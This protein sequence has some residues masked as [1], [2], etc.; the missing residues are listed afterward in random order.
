MKISKRETILIVSIIFL[1]SAA[2]YYIYFLTPTIEEIDDLAIAIEQ[3]QLKILSMQTAIDQI[4]N[5]K[6][7]I[8]ELEAE[9][10]KQSENIPRGISQPIQLVSVS[11]IMNSKCDYLI[12]GFNPGA[13]EYENYQKNIVDM[14]FATTYEELLLILEEF[15][16]LSMTNQIA[17]MNITF[18]G[19][20]QSYYTGILEGNYLIVG[21]SAEFYSF[22]SDPDAE[23]I[24]EQSFE[25]GIIEYKNPFRA[26]LN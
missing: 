12:I 18:Q 9:L 23:P 21:M 20:P 6:N 22:Y 25:D 2:A 5:V 1:I 7:E 16:A 19:N 15:K 11:N 14:S 3:K 24:G 10:E 26:T 8:A 17:K 13:E 4:D